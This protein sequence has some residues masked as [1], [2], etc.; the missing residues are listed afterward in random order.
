MNKWY[1]FLHNVGLC[2]KALLG[3]A[4]RGGPT[5]HYKCGIVNYTP[6]ND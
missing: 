4:C 3:Y 6:L 2:E 1:R 5:P